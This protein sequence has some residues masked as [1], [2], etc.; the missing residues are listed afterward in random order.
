MST[1]IGAAPPA[2][3]AVDPYVARPRVIVMTDIA[4]EPDDQMSLV[5]F[6][7]YS[8]QFDVEGLVA[9]TSTWMKTQ[10]RPD[11]IHSVLDAYDLV[12]PNLLKHAPGFPAAAALREKVVA[13]QPGYGMAAVGEGKA[14][15]RRRAHPARGHER[16]HAAAV[17][18]GVG[19]HEHAGPGARDGQGD[20]HARAGG[21]HRLQAARLRH[22]GPGRC[23]PVAAA[24]VS[25]AALRRHAVDAGRRGVLLRDVDRDQRR[26]VLQERARA[27]TSR[28]S[29]TSG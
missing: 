24:G 5:R 10:V 22:L 9:T 11:V 25:V 16:R 18:A 2:L 4:N 1:S 20:A 27:P 19:R 14:N 21:G 15:A 6:L 23:G 3:T 17:G 12:Q 28:R 7:L 29:P 8:N 13:G 26:P